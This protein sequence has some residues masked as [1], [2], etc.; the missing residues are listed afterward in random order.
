[1]I[2]SELRQLCTFQLEEDLYGLPLDDVVEVLNH[3]PMTPV[4][5]APPA[6]AGLMNLRGEVVTAI[7]LRN[8]LGLN[9]C[10]PG[11]RPMNVVV[12]KGEN[13]VSLLVDAIG[14]VVSVNDEDFEEP[15][16]TLDGAAREMIRGAHKLE[17]RLLLE[18]DTAIVA[19]IG[20]RVTETVDP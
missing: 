15:P 1:M 20:S 12:R 9:A 10:D 5:L 8:R 6:V 4:P 17:D 14:D 11:R 2:M 3:Q 7:D 19:D 13:V 18:L 16:D